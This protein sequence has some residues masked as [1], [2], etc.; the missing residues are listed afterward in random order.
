MADPVIH[1]NVSGKSFEAKLTTLT[2]NSTYFKALYARE[3]RYLSEELYIDRD[4]DIFD[5]L[6]KTWRGYTIAT[7]IDIENIKKD[8]DYYGC[9]QFVDDDDERDKL[10]EFLKAGAID[11]GGI[12][13]SIIQVRGVLHPLT[14]K[15]NTHKLTT[16]KPECDQINDCERCYL[17]IPTESLV[18]PVL[19]S[20][21]REYTLCYE[22]DYDMCRSRCLGLMWIV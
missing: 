18:L 20:K 19:D 22:W 10:R 4:P 11:G 1:I 16:D 2:D 21:I 6:L 15:H 7:D 9:K 14:D 8:C 13:Y 3:P 12:T 17:S 5:L